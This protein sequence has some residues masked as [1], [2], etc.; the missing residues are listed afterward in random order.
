MGTANPMPTLPPLCDSI[1]ELM[2][3]T[4]PAASMSGP[5]ELPGLMAASVWMTLSIWNPLGA[6]IWR[7]SAETIPAVA[8][9]SRANGLPIATTGSPTRTL[10]ESPKA[11]GWSWSAGRSTLRR[12][13]SVDSS[14]PTTCAGTA[15]E[16]SA[17]PSWT[18][19]LL[20]PFTT[21][22]L[23]RTCPCLSMTKPE[24]VATPPLEP[25]NGLN[26]DGCCGAWVAWM[27]ATPGES[28]R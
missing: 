7:W 26:G 20:E 1:C 2:P 27:K 19:T 23:V 13:M 6:F 21:W 17:L 25:P 12:A 10:E 16:L 8:V 14:L 18:V 3:I 24:P 11:T 4:R 5:P 15:E 22:A 9:R 28:E